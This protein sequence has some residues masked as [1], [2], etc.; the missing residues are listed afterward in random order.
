MPLDIT[1]YIAMSTIMFTLLTLGEI[2]HIEENG[3]DILSLLFV[4]LYAILTVTG[5]ALL[6]P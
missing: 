6:I 1:I 3:A 5:L 2:S 4:P